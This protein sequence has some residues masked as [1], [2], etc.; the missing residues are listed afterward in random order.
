MNVYNRTATR[1]P[2]RWPR[3]GRAWPRRARPRSASIIIAMVGGDTASRA[4]WLGEH[5]AL[6]GAEP[7]AVLVECSTLSIAWVRE[8]AGLAAERGLPLLDAPVT[9]SKDAAA[10]GA[11]RLLVGGDSAALGAPARR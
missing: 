1:K 2:R 10:N 3:A 7:G 6:G 4:V 8:L 9:G 11:L 5:G